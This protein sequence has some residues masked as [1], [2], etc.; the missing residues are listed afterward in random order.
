MKGE[1]TMKLTVLKNGKNLPKSKYTWDKDNK[2]FA[3]KESGLVISYEGSDCTFDT[4]SNCTFDTGSNCT[5]DTGSDCTFDTG[6]NCTF[7]TGSNCTFDTGYD[8]TF[9]TGFNCTFDTGSDCV[10]IRRDVFEFFELK[11]GIIYKLCPYNIKGYLTKNENEDAFYIDIDG[12]R[13]EHII[14]DGIL[15]KVVK[16]RGNVYHVINHGSNDV[17]YLIKAGDIYSHGNTLK[18]ARE[19]LK[20]KISNRDTSEFENY[21][22]DDELDQTTLIR[23]YRAITG[24]CETGTRYFCENNKLP[25][26]C[27][28]RKAIELTKGQY[29][30]EQFKEFFDDKE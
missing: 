12:Q 29:N 11:K 6:D 26:K 20:Y 15:S 10:A 14:A 25:K 9:K 13:V 2:V 5:F 28:I 22:F 16:K 1:K 17:T 30:W 23:M 24:A 27:T 3:T 21:K 19:S 18:E 8:C 4:G 7:K